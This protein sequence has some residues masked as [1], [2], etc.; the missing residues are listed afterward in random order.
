LVCSYHAADV[1]CS[2]RDGRQEEG[3][4]L[5][6]V[7]GTVKWFSPEKGWGFVTSRDGEDYFC[8][9]GDIIMDGFKYLQPGAG[10]EFDTV[11]DDQGR[12]KAI[13]I[14][15]EVGYVGAVQENNA[16]D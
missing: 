2:G 9:Y 1:V 11:Q 3:K 6:S 8:H 12:V 15:Q 5:R 16:R 7:Q 10:V 14:I 13:N 4:G